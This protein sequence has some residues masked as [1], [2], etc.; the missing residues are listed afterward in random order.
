METLSKSFE[1][2]IQWKDWCDLVSNYD[3][4]FDDVD[5]DN[6]FLQFGNC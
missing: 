6:E 2:A 4:D 1:V 3:N 5:F